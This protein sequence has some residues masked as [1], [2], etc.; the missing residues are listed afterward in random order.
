MS[1][2]SKL[3]AVESVNNKITN[4]DEGNIK[5][6]PS[7]NLIHIKK[8]FKLKFV[9]DMNSSSPCDTE[10]KL[11]TKNKVTAVVQPPLPP[12]SPP[13]DSPLSFVKQE[14]KDD[15]YE[16]TPE[17]SV[18]EPP[19]ISV[20][21]QE[22]ERKKPIMCKD[23]VRKKCTR[24]SAC[25][26]AHQIDLSQL[27]GIY[28]FCRDFENGRCNRP[29]CN[30][31]HATTFEKE[32]FFRTGEDLP[33]HT[34]AHLKNNPV[35]PMPTENIHHNH[36]FSNPP[37]QLL[38]SIGTAPVAPPFSGK[39]PP[40]SL[41]AP[42]PTL[43]REWR[44]VDVFTSTHHECDFKEPPAKTCN[45]CKLTKLRLEHS[46]AQVAQAMRGLQELDEKLEHINKKNNRLHSILRVLL[47]PRRTLEHVNNEFLTPPRLSTCT[48][49]L[50]EDANKKALLAQ[51]KLLLTKIL[52]G[53]E[54]SPVEGASTGA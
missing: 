6:R 2:Q 17:E 50:Q 15:E 20:S 31:V 39:I 27:K 29:V 36:I 42:R 51:M 10:C 38:P 5:F 44:P 12:N 14:V 37:P 40:A 3:P 43:K 24:G 18:E 34:L 11:E 1:K 47:K 46:K 32:Q 4:K 25:N 33:E 21:L 54:E 19:Q 23:F 48:S 7:P 8:Y 30:F 9:E 41:P 22:P 45:R 28:K 35:Q 52:L 53:G 13:P 16:Q 26:F 49:P